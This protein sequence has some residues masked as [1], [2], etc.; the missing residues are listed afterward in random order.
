M[1]MSLTTF[2][3]LS[4][5]HDSDVV[6]L[7]RDI[8]VRFDEQTVHSVGDTFEFVHSRSVILSERSY[9]GINLIE[10]IEAL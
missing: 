9:E 10:V 7:H 4:T 2:Q 3:S 1:S 5:V 8:A 6:S